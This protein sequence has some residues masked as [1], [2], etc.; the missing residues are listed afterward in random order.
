M[1]GCANSGSVVRDDV[2][3]NPEKIEQIGETRDM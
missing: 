3:E 1:E 2:C